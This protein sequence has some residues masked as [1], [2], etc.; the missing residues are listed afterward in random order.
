MAVND[1]RVQEPQPPWLLSFFVLSTGVFVL[2]VS[3]MGTGTLA[4]AGW[5][6]RGIE[7]GIGAVLVAFGLYRYW[8]ARQKRNDS[9]RADR[10]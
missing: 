3:L 2:S 9:A 6:R 4:S 7:A 1:L 10:P 8:R 5:L